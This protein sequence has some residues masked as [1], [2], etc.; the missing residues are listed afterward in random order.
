MNGQGYAR[1]V[2]NGHLRRAANKLRRVRWRDILVVEDGAPCHS[3][4][5]AREVRARLGI[6]SLVHFPSSPDL[7]PIDNF[8]ILLKT[9][10]S[11]LS[12]WVTNLDMLWEQIQACWVDIGQEY[13]NILIDKIPG[14][15]EKVHK[16]KCKIILFHNL[17]LVAMLY[18][19]LIPCFDSSW[20]KASSCINHSF[21]DVAK[22]ALAL[23]Y[24]C[25]PSM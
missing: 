14:M 7:N 22:A 4:K 12:T 15:V 16:A 17:D 24:L 11:Q 18:T 9:K 6:S 1:M 10:V 25:M 8:Q 21:W 3:C 2:L 13:I 5:L 23:E 20:H 19:I